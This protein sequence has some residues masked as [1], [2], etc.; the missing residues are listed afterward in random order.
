MECQLPKYHSTKSNGYSNIDI[1]KELFEFESRPYVSQGHGFLDAVVEVAPVDEDRVHGVL[2][3][4][5]RRF[6]GAHGEQRGTGAVGLVEPGG[7]G[8]GRGGRGQVGFGGWVGFGGERGGSGWVLGG[9]R[10]GGQVGF[11]GG[12]GGLGGEGEML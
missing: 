7:G 10:G 3:E 9:E 6:G 12:R 2:R 4:T 11:K 1:S 8:F 5:L